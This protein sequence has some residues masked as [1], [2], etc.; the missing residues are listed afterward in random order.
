MRRFRRFVK[1]NTLLFFRVSVILFLFALICLLL[2]GINT[3]VADFFNGTVSHA[4]RYALAKMTDILPF[5][6]GEALLLVGV[7]TALIVL[8]VIV[9]CTRT[10]RCARRTLSFVLA[11]TLCVASLHMLTLGV[12]YRTTKLDEKLGLTQDKVSAEELKRVATVMAS[13][14]NAMVNDVTYGESGSSLMPYDTDELSEK[15]CRAYDAV[16][17]HY[18]IFHN[19]TSRVKPVLFSRGMSYTHLI[20]VYSF[21]TGESNL[22]VD[23]PDYNFP[24]TTAHEFAHQRGIIRENEANFMAFLVCAASDDLYIRYSGYLNTYVYVANA[25]YSASPD[26]YREVSS[27]LDERIRGELRAE[28]RHSAQYANNPVGNVAQKANDSYLKFNGTVEGS[29]SYGLVV[30]LTVAYYRDLWQTPNDN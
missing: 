14:L 22:N 5:S 11:V 7:P 13:E 28:Q 19:F 29:R 25:L 9:F 20:G 23:Y 3:G 1:N 4:V 12:A 15:I 21:Y 26:D 2:S 8:L 6:L 30:D 27:M 18:G 17:A 24:C 10:R 16:E